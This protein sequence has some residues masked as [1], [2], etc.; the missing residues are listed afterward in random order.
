MA[1]HTRT[2]NVIHNDDANTS[3]VFGSINKAKRASRKL[4]NMT[5]SN[6]RTPTL[7]CRVGDGK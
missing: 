4:E 2:S 3:E 7:H 6:K 5:N 1:H